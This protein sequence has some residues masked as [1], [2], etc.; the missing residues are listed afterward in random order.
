M[1]IA[2]RPE[3]QSRLKA[4]FRLIL[5]IPILHR[6]LRRAVDSSRR[7]RVSWL[8]IVFRGYQ[9]AG[10]HN[11]LVFTTAFQA[12]AG[13]YLLLLTDVYPPVGAEATQVGDTRP[14]RPPPRTAALPAAP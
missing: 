1:Q 10:V 11:A 13:G 3:R 5:A 7:G 4:F 9:P 2:P 8:T 6:R 14:R 12:R